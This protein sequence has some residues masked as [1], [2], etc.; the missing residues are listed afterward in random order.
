MC[1]KQAQQGPFSGRMLMLLPG[2]SRGT[3]SSRSCQLEEEG[4]LAVLQTRKAREPRQHFSMLIAQ[5]T[6]SLQSGKNQKIEVEELS[7]EV[8]RLAAATKTAK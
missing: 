7:G 2:Y 3:I 4:N 1:N 5:A 6:S 8:V